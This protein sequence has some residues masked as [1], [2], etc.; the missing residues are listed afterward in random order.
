MTGLVII[1]LI[2][3]GIVTNIP[4]YDLQNR[5]AFSIQL[6]FV[7][8]VLICAL[9]QIIYLKIIRRKYDTDQ[10]VGHLRRYSE[11]TYYIVS[12]TQYLIIALLLVT[13]LEF[14]VLNQYHSAILLIQILLSLGLS[15]GI[16]GL[17]AFRFLIWIKYRRDYL[18]VAYTAAAI[19]IS[20]NSIFIGLFMSLEMQGKPMVID[21]STFYS[22]YMI[23]GYQLHGIQSNIQFASFIALWIASIFLLRRQRKKWGAIKFYLVIALPLVYYLG[24][25]QLIISNALVQ[26]QILSPIQSYTFNVVNSIL[27]KPVGGLLFGIAFWMVGRSVSDKGIGDYMKLSAFGIMLLSISN[28]DAGIY[29]LPYPPFGLPTI[30]FV[31]LSSYLL[32]IGIYYSSLSISINTELRK[33]IESSVEEQFKFISKIGRSQMEN[34][35][36]NRVKMITKRSAKMLEE[37]SGIQTQLEDNEI[38]EYV[39]FV[40]TEREK[41]IK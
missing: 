10:V 21:P 13:L 29:L 38:E 6:F 18:I 9:S 34:E 24:A 12:V 5:Q 20:I 32:F 16:S 25:V 1:I 27:T 15:A 11:L 41:M 30:T 23:T 36:A 14:T 35:I 37:N 7:V 33:R 31:G 8:E 26:N 2:F 40:V 19:L 3:D 22:N 4:S 39:K 28:Q 17:L